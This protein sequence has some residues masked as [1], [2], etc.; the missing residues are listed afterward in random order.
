MRKSGRPLEKI[1]FKTAD[2]LLA[3]VG[4]NDVQLP[5]V[6]SAVLRKAD[7]GRWL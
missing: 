6:L 4:R 7:L 3:A 5:D 1:G 2:E